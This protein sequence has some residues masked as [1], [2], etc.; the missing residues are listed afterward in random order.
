MA[1]D[2]IH[3]FECPT[4]VFYGF[5]AS[6]LVGEHLGE[7]GVTRALIVSDPG[8]LGAGAVDRVA[9]HIRNAGIDVVTYAE[10]EQNPT[11]TNV[12]QVVSLWNERGCDG[13]VGLGGGSSMD[14]AKASGAVIANG[15]SIADYWGKDKIPNPPPPVVCIPTTCGTGAELT[16][17]VV[18]TDPGRHFKLVCVSRN[19]AARVAL[20]DPELVLT[21]PPHV[22]A[23]TGADAL[24]HALE[25]FLNL[26]SDPLLDSINIRAIRMIGQNLRAAV[27][28]RDREAIGQ[29]SLARTMTGIAFNMNANAIVHAASTP[30]T[31]HYGVPHG[32]ANAIFMPAG[33][34]FLRPACEPKLRAVAEALGQDV[35]ALSDEEAARRGVAAVRELLRH[36]EL[37]GTLREFGLDPSEV[38]IPTLV[39]DAMKS[40][41]IATNPRPVTREDLAELYKVVVG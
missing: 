11:T 20:V 16:F 26:G 25:S 19:L 32:V 41:N 39:E 23:A 40:R 6:S 12:E 13:L 7:L 21:A 18:I 37:P 30:V 35:E 22:I 15:G 2:S 1:W 36:V 17:V 14:C 34:D 38:D 24:A 31:A 5:G 4:R 10:T 28:D 29:V 9:E 8:V 33:L 3:L 27:Y